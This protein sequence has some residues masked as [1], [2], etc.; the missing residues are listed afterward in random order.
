MKIWMRHLRK[1]LIGPHGYRTWIVVLTTAIAAYFGAY[2]VLESRHDRQLNRA[3]FERNNFINM[4]TSGNRGTF[5]AAM[6]TFGPIQT[7]SIPSEPPI[8]CPWRW[9][10]VEMP[11]VVPL[12]RWAQ[13]YFGQC[14]AEMCGIVDDDGGYRIDLLGANFSNAILPKALLAGSRLMNADLRAASFSGAILN[15]ANLL[16]ADL[17]GASLESVHLGMAR[18]DGADLRNATLSGADLFGAIFRTPSR[19]IRL[20]NLSEP[21]LIPKGKPAQLQGADLAT[22]KNLT[23][24]QLRDTYWD[25][26]TT[27]PEGL[28][29]P[30]EHNLP[31]SPCVLQ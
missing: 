11:N 1:D 5:L 31:E 14:T 19:T 29:R 26:N 25:K 18:L 3:L 4:V 20:D 12:Q 8:F 23:I 6:V 24:E 10:E 15:G 16:G 17:R 21:T 9:F 7:I 30:C 22:A 28:E 27:W 13:N 2:A